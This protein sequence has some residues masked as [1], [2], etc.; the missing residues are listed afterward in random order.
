MSCAFR[1]DKPCGICG[2]GGPRSVHWGPSPAKRVFCQGD[3]NFSE[4]AGRRV[5]PNMSELA[6]APAD[7]LLS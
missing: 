6:P 7:K 2:P 1:V 5:V 4:R 3:V